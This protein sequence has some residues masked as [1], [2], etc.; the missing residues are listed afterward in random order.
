MT[1]KHKTCGFQNLQKS[2]FSPSLC[3]T[4][5]NC[6][7]MLDLRSFCPLHSLHSVLLCLPLSLKHTRT[8]FVMGSV[9]L[10]SA[11]VLLWNF[12]TSCVNR[13]DSSPSY[14]PAT[15]LIGT[16]PHVC[17]WNNVWPFLHIVSHISWMSSFGLYKRLYVAIGA[18][19]S[20][21]HAHCFCRRCP[22]S[23]CCSS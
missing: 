15:S 16:H 2:V 9:S 11:E 4:L 6:T 18:L 12:G 7:I 19:A 20:L 1:E 10:I 17:A 5:S 13:N 21:S 14:R 3:S 23:H 22:C 8:Q